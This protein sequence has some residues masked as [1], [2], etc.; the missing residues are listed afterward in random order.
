MYRKKTSPTVTAINII[1]TIAI[2]EGFLVITTYPLRLLR[3]QR[4]RWPTVSLPLIC[5]TKAQ[6]LPLLCFLTTTFLPLPMIA[7]NAL[8]GDLW[9]CDGHWSLFFL[10][11][12]RRLYFSFLHPF[13]PSF[14]YFPLKIFSSFSL[15]V[16]FP[17]I[18][19]VHL[20]SVA[21]VLGLA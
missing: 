1:I 14:P 10:F 7:A 16:L 19:P 15:S 6:T 20:K 17:L 12:F 8:G 13:L 3:N 9:T 4:L 21:S 5:W 11:L 18:F 2:P